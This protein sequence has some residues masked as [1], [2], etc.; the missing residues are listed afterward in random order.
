[1]L[2]ILQ[3]VGIFWLCI[4][5]LLIALIAWKQILIIF[6]IPLG[7]F[8]LIALPYSPEG[9]EIVGN[10][11]FYVGLPILGTLLICKIF[12]MCM[13]ACEKV[14]VWLRAKS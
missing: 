11:L 1:M 8:L 3:F 7:L 13:R 14:S 10:I 2:D 5:G 9:K 12:V 6:G 4:L